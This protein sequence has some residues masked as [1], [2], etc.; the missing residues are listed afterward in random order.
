MSQ[1][2]KTGPGK[3]VASRNVTLRIWL[4]SLDF[5]IFTM[6]V[7]CGE[8]KDSLSVGICS[9]VWGFP[10][11][12]KFIIDMR[13]WLWFQELGLCHTEC[14]ENVLEQTVAAAPRDGVL[15][16]SK[17]SLQGVLVGQRLFCLFTL[18]TEG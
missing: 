10:S 16:D 4:K 3:V 9:R 14:R 5:S 1:P 8:G 18:Y 6:L 7:Q 12:Q 17:T 2:L 13:A 15:P 11:L